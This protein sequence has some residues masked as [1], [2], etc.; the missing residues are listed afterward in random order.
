MNVREKFITDFFFSGNPWF[1]ESQKQMDHSEAKGDKKCFKIDISWLLVYLNIFGSR[2][3]H[4]ISQLEIQNLLT[5][6]L[7]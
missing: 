6:I 4:Y 1:E 3:L 7:I 5:P 2:C